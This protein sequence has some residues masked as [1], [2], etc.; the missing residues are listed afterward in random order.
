MIY[1]VFFILCFILTS[2]KKEDENKPYNIIIT[3][4]VIDQVTEQPVDGATVSLGK[5]TYGMP[6]EGLKSPEQSTLTGPDGKYKLIT[7]TVPY[8]TGSISPGRYFSN[9]IAFIASKSGYI[10]CNRQEIL[11]YGAQ[12]SSIN[13]K[14]YHSSELNLHIKNDTTDNID[15]VDIKLIK[16]TNAFP[17]TVMTLICNKRTLD[18]TYL[19][20]D[21]FGNFEYT[22]QVLKPGGQPF[23]PPIKYSISPKPD[24][25]NNLDISF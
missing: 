15:A 22:I 6:I 8:N 20:K 7:G 21:L 19:I 13:L 16:S 12:N 18:S 1:I 25:M 5:Q 17:L 24:E 4:V 2:C 3:G 23:S 9:G 10:G 14:L 11:Y